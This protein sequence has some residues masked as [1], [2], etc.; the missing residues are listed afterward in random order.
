MK[1][2]LRSMV[3][4]FDRIM[5]FRGETIVNVPIPPDAS[6]RFQWVGFADPGLEIKAY[7]HGWDVIDPDDPNDMGWH[8]PAGLG[9]EN[10]ATAWD[11]PWRPGTQHRLVI[12]CWDNEDHLTRMIIN[13]GSPAP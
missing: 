10:M 9:P 13:L 8:G 2:I 3:T 6:S 11:G 4:I 12:H 5:G 1:N 7:R